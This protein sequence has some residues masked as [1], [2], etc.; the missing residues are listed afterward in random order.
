MKWFCLA[1]QLLPVDVPNATGQA[2]VIN[3]QHPSG[4]LGLIRL[5]ALRLRTLAARRLR[6]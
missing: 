2:G 5:N 3:F 4:E 1:V 6:S